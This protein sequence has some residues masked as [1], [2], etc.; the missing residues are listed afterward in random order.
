MI[1][2]RLRLQPRDSGGAAEVLL[3]ES[4]TDDRR[5]W[6]ALLRPGKRLKVGEVLSH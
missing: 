2:A 4:L 3:L 1:P 5:T 6:E